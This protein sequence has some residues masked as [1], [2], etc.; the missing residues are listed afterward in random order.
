MK[1][2]ADP[3][4]TLDKEQARR[5]TSWLERGLKENPQSILYLLGLGNL[6]ERMENYD[7]A[8]DLYRTAIAND[9]DGIA[10]NN[11]AWLIALKGGR[12]SEALDLINKAIR[13]QGAGAGIPGHPRHDLPR[14][15]ATAVAP[16]PTSSRPSMPPPTAPSIFHLAQAYLKINEHEKARKILEA[17]KSRGCPAASI[18]WRWAP[19]TSWPVRWGSP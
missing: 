9:R 1:I 3:D 6:N 11:L 17:G 7:K 2:L 19:T 4:A 12:G 5:V 15:P 18:P 8:M 16:S 10:A 14:P 13:A